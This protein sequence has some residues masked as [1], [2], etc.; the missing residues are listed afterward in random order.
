MKFLRKMLHS[1]I[2]LACGGRVLFCFPRSRLWSPALKYLNECN[3]LRIWAFWRTGTLT[4]TLT[5]S[6]GWNPVVQWGAVRWGVLDAQDYP[7][8]RV[9]ASGG[10]KLSYRTWVWSEGKRPF[11]ACAY[12]LACVQLS[13]HALTW[14]PPPYLP[15]TFPRKCS[16]LVIYTLLCLAFVHKL[17]DAFVSLLSAYHA[18]ALCQVVKAFL[19]VFWNLLGEKNMKTLGDWALGRGR[20]H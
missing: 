9:I 10:L 13:L 3:S 6:S 8:D 18:S 16:M 19:I 12:C 17:F 2:D 4:E 14:S 7:A 20:A 1:L 11:K 15:P 5:L